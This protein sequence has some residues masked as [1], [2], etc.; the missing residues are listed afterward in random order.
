L[1]LTHRPLAGLSNLED[2]T[3][4][5][6]GYDEELSKNSVLAYLFG[7]SSNELAGGGIP[8][9]LKKVRVK[10]GDIGQYAFA[11]L[12]NVEEIVIDPEVENIG[13][14]AF[15]NCSSLSEL[16]MPVRNIPTEELESKVVPWSTRPASSAQYYGIA[17]S[18]NAKIP[19]DKDKLLT[20]HLDGGDNGKGF[21]MF[22]YCLGLGKV[23]I[24]NA[25]IHYAMFAY[26]YNL[27]EVTIGNN[28][29]EIHSAS[30]L[31]CKSL[32]EIVIPDSVKGLGKSYT[33]AEV[34]GIRL[35]SSS[36]GMFY[37]SSITKAVIGNGTEIVPANM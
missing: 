15:Y 31:S 24:D 13:Y 37:G 6:I 35:G 29:E 11:N 33:H 34:D 16:T 17:G 22:D 20:V 26:C 19:Y 21:S 9:S 36:G 28:V 4:P 12:A 18:A 32:T 1:P 5:Y 7:Y 14:Y 3:L 25:N 8:S 27:T 30:F 2:L 23:T 10:G